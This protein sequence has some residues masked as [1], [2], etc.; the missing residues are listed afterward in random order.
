MNKKDHR[1]GQLTITHHTRPLR[2]GWQWRWWPSGWKPWW[3]RTSLL[4]QAVQCSRWRPWHCSSWTLCP[5]YDLGRGRKWG[6]SSKG[7][8]CDT[9]GIVMSS[10]MCGA[11]GAPAWRKWGEVS[12]KWRSCS[13]R[14]PQ[15]PTCSSRRNIDSVCEFFWWRTFYVWQ[16]KILLFHIKWSTSF[17]D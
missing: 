5:I 8:A 14:L 2:W 11:Q 17:N 9:A 1:V 15:T 10:I 7:G 13:P 4:F 3:W 6:G 12:Q 16:G